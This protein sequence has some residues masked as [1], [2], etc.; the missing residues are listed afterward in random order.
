MCAEKVNG[1][2]TVLLRHEKSSYGPKIADR[3]Y[4]FT[5]DGAMQEL[6]QDEQTAVTDQRTQAMRTA[7][8][9]ALRALAERGEVAVVARNSPYNIGRQM[10]Q[11][12]LLGDFDADEARRMVSALIG[13]GTL[14]DGLP[15]NGESGRPRILASSGRPKVGIW[16]RPLE[17]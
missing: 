12:G 16:F 3:R 2:H 11:H 10:E 13:D 9:A 8:L 15:M 7:V 4:V 6:T 5:Q 17:I 1:I 14:A